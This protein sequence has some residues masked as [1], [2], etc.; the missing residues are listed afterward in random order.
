MRRQPYYMPLSQI[1]HFIQPIRLPRI[2]PLLS[3]EKAR[4]SSK[5]FSAAGL[6]TTSPLWS[7]GLFSRHIKPLPMPD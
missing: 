7:S 5:V 2:L 1:L 4:E 6:L 3:Y